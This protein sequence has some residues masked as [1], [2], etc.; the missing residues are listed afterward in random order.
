MRA[1][2][3]RAVLRSLVP[4]RPACVPQKLNATSVFHQWNAVVYQ[5]R[6]GRRLWFD[7]EQGPSR[8]GR[9]ASGFAVGKNSLLRTIDAAVP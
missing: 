1:L 5:S 8:D 6:E 3:C 4:A 7:H 9:T 2:I